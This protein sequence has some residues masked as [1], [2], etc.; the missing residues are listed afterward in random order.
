MTIG[1]K[2][3]RVTPVLLI[4]AVLLVMRPFS[5]KGWGAY[6]HEISGRAAAMKLPKEMPKFFRQSADQLAYL[7]P[8]PDRWRDRVESDLDKAM[9]SALAAD[10]F[11]DMELVPKTAA[12]AIN[13]YEF[14][15]ELVKAGQKPT[16]AGF[17]PYRILELFQT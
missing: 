13:R 15:A 7:N 9:D 6:G 8:E 11:L 5:V 1:L 17:L 2:F 16:A 4:T 10:H 12:G 3:W 14:C